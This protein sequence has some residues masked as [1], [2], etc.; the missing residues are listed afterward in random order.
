M[1]GGARGHDLDEFVV[2]ARLVLLVQTFRLVEIRKNVCLA[3]GQVPADTFAEV[4][5]QGDDEG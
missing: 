5:D 4:R 3:L 2:N 1:R